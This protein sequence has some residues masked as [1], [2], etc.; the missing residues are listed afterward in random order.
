MET[1]EPEAT[2]K[3]SVHM[4]TVDDDP[5]VRQMIA[6]YLGDNDIRVSTVAN[7]RGVCWSP[8]C[9]RRNVFCRVNS[10]SPFRACTTTRSTTA[11]PTRRSAA[12]AA[13]SCPNVQSPR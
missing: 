9:R 10:C 2:L 13:S 12:F 1:V 11:P 4:L 7:G 6:D 3:S 5:S 8:F